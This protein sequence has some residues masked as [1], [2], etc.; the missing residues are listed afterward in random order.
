ML[1]WVAVRQCL[2]LAVRQCL[3][4]ESHGFRRP[5]TFRIGST[6]HHLLRA[7]PNLKSMQQ[8]REFFH[9]ALRKLGAKRH[10][11]AGGISYSEYASWVT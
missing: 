2:T 9:F 4:D 1:P 3:T 8:A 11:G 5:H 7:V 6:H 10:T